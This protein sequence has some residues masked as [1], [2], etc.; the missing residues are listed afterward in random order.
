MLNNDDPSGRLFLIS[1]KARSLGTDVVGANSV[2]HMDA[3]WNPTREV[4]AILRVY[5]FGQKKP[6]FVCTVDGLDVNRLPAAMLKS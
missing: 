6:V 3:S 1:T 5:G 2:V 4:Q